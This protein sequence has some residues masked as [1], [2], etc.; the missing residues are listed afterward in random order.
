[1]DLHLLKCGGYGGL[2]LWTQRMAR[3]LGDLYFGAPADPP[4]AHAKSQSELYLAQWN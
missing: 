1:M 4:F 2:P 3:R